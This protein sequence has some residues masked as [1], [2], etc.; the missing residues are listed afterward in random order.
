[1]V[2][3]SAILHVEEAPCHSGAPQGSVIGPLLCLLYINDLP[4]AL[5]DSA[6]LFADDVKMAYPLSQSSRLLTSFS[7][8]WAWSE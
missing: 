8:A 5:D 7:S 4:A 3:V 2:S 6:F 1:M